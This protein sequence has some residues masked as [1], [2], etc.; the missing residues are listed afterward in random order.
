M[1]PWIGVVACVALALGLHRLNERRQRQPLH[2]P[3][4]KLTEGEQVYWLGVFQGPSGAGF[5][6]PRSMYD[7]FYRGI[8]DPRI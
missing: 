4:R 7:Y 1:S 8:D 3:W 5:P 2:P 6:S